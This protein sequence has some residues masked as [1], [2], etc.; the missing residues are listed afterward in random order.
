MLICIN[1]DN[2]LYIFQQICYLNSATGREKN[3]LESKL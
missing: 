2:K 3:R 1:I